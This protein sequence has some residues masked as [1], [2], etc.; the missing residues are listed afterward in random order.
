MTFG[1]AVA[2]EYAGLTIGRLAQRPAILRRHPHR[3]LALL[4]KLARVDAPDS[5][6]VGQTLGGEFPVPLLQPGLIPLILAD[7]ALEIAHALRTVQLQGHRLNNPCRY[8]S[9]NSLGSVRRNVSPNNCVNSL[10]SRPTHSISS[11]LSLNSGG[12]LGSHDSLACF[13]RV[14]LG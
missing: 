13:I 9:H 7:E 14:L 11:M 3:G 10:S 12:S 6:R 2:N 4:G 1:A 8:S 5:L